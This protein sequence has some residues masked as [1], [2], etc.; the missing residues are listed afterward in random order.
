MSDGS[1]DLRVLLVAYQC[2]SGMGSV[3]QIGWEWYRRLSVRLRLTL[4]THVRNRPALELAGAP[5]DN[6]EVIFVDT[7]WFARPLFRMA[8]L[9]FPRSEHAA[10][11]LSA[12]DFFVFDR[13]ALRMLR[14]RIAGGKSWDLAHLVTPV[15]TLA[16]TRLY[17]LGLPLIKGPLN[18]GIGTPRGF[19]SILRDEYPWIFPLR[20]IGRF[21]DM[22][23]G[24]T[25]NSAAILTATEAT[26]HRIPQRYRSR[27][28]KMLEN[29]VDLEV[30][31]PST[32]PAPPST[33][34]PLRVLFVGRLMPF[35]ALGLLLQAVDRVSREFPIELS[36][37]G[38]GPMSSRWRA[39]AEHR[40][41]ADKVTFLGPRSLGEVASAM[42]L[43]HVFCLPSVRES[44]GAVLLEAMACARP[45][46]AIDF[47]GPAEIVD[48]TVGRAIP[49]NGVEE[50][51]AA[52][53]E[54]L[55]DIVRE[56][57][58]WRRLGEN[59]YRRA[60]ESFS[61]EAKVD[62]ALVL[63]RELLSESAQGRAM[64]E[65]RMHPGANLVG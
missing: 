32:W 52:L 22:C 55:R 9:L 47:G 39:E 36:V 16:A 43:A 51:V 41:L 12:L 30:F 27:C 29:G 63:Y 37:I 2:G 45:V 13:A 61:W 19:S 58:H 11:M 10:F 50:T 3:S 33:N 31:T 25:R 59:G 38:D 26:L 40:G 54:A 24:S 49:P 21:V 6:S 20:N 56:P 53:A 1:E 4:I 15:T 48:D 18:C 62:R 28:I 5:F 60:C 17:R 46:L 44:G 8:K 14:R 35:K 23:L 7:E 34:E 65:V 64:N 57:D 42:R